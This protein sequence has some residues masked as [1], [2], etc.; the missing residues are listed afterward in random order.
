MVF[1]GNNEKMFPKNPFA[2]NGNS[3][4]APQQQP[5]PGMAGMIQPQGFPSPYANDA[6]T[7]GNP[8]RNQQQEPEPWGGIQNLQDYVNYG[9]D[10]VLPYVPPSTTGIIEQMLGLQ[11]QFTGVSLPILQ[12]ILGS[13]Q[14]TYDTYQQY[15]GPEMVL[16]NE[17][18]NILGGQNNNS[19]E[20]M[21]QLSQQYQRP[22][23]SASMFVG[24]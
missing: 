22:R 2:G 13:E 23:S 3:P 14:G 17:L 21:L 15:F 4:F 10:A 6:L 24:F 7:P 11:G 1:S 9:P 20:A 16:R 8:N 18:L 19:L 12:Q 5:G